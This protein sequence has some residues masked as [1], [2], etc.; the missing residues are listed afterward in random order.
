M[1]WDSLFRDFEGQIEHGLESEARAV[2]CEEERLRVGR[3]QLRDRLAAWAHGDDTPGVPI[4]VTVRSGLSLVLWVDAVGRDWLAGHVHD[5]AQ[6][7][8]VLVPLAAVASVGVPGA[9]LARTVRA[10]EP[11]QALTR[12]LALSVAL[13]D[14]GE[15]RAPVEVQLP[16]LRLHGLI[17]HVGADH[18]DLHEH[19]AAAH[20]GASGGPAF[21]TADARVRMIPVDAVQWLRY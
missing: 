7:P 21:G 5:A 15:R 4:E 12:R 3:L 10:A 1:R 17:G 9:G 14:L 19:D 11:P 20:A 13:R 16:T 8:A 6:R 2:R 18:V